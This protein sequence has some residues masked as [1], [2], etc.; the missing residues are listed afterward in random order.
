MIVYSLQCAEGHDFE[1]WFRN[2]GAFD[3]QDAEGKLLCP[4]CE[5]HAVTKA[6]MAPALSGAVASRHSFGP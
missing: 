3:E 4:V 5:T 1:G 6:P 2:S